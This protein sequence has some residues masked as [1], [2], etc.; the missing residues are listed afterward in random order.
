MSKSAVDRDAETV[1]D[2]NGIVPET[3]KTEMHSLPVQAVN[4]RDKS[5]NSKIARRN[6]PSLFLKKIRKTHVPLAITSNINFFYMNKRKTDIWR[7]NL[8]IL[9]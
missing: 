4:K 1:L 2:K 6:G 9:T 5:I 7:S 3:K 8:G